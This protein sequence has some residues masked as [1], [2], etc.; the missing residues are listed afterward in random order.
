[1]LLQRATKPSAKKSMP[2]VLL[3]DAP[4][5]DKMPNGLKSETPAFIYK[6]NN[7]YEST[8][9]RMP[10]LA[11]VAADNMPVKSKMANPPLL[12]PGANN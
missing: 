6:G 2:K 7:V 12:S 3:G 11:P 10:V 8:I 5:G 9:D 1:M 4:I